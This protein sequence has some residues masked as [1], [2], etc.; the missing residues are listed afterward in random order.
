MNIDII[1]GQ[2]VEPMSGHPVLAALV[3]RASAPADGAAV[4]I[5]TVAELAT[6]NTPSSPW[7]HIAGKIYDLTPFFDGEAE[8]PGGNKVLRKQ[9]GTDATELFA[10]FHYARGQAVQMA[11]S[12]CIGVLGKVSS[13]PE[14]AVADGGV[15]SAPA[16]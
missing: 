16:S 14:A 7:V 10:S 11:D 1:C 6:H 15:E 13:S 4:R 12:M 8:H 2:L 3:S 9:L 5:I